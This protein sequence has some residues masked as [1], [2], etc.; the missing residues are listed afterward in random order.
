MIHVKLLLLY[1]LNRINFNRMNLI[2]IHFLY[3]YTLY[4]LHLVMECSEMIIPMLIL[5]T[6]IRLIPAI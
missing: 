4:V 5:P 2:Y 6:R 1:K 3:L